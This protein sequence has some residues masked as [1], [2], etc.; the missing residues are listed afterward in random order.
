VA[1]L[2][3]V[4]FCV[5]M[6]AGT[7]QVGRVLLTY[8]K[9]Q[10]LVKSIFLLFLISVSEQSS[11]NIHQVQ[12]LVGGKDTIQMVLLVPINVTAGY[13]LILR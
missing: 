13:I 1:W 5:R 9:R 7:I 2:A 4:G 10:K 12:L 3:E 8:Q 6:S 11:L